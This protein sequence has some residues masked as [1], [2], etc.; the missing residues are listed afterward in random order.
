MANWSTDT[1]VYLI[2][3][4]KPHLAKALS[5][6]TELHKE[7]WQAIDYLRHSTRSNF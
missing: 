3:Y 5:G 4:P 2:W 1:N 6:K 7:V